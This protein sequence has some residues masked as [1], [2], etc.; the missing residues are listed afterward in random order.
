MQY[1]QGRLTSFPTNNL[2]SDA[3]CEYA[4]N[5]G[6]RKG[7]VHAAL[8]ITSGLVGDVTET[9]RWCSCYDD[10]DEDI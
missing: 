2:R 4:G 7:I 1:L 8:V 9:K 10:N 6:S 3:D 5:I